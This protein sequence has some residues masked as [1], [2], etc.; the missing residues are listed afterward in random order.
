[1]GSVREKAKRIASID[2]LETG[3]CAQ[4]WSSLGGAEISCGL[5]KEGDILV[6]SDSESKL[7]RDKSL[8]RAIKNW[9]VKYV[10][11]HCE[12]SKVNIRSVHQQCK[13]GESVEEERD[14]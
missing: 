3:S 13:T 2:E 10:C 6:A 7:W 1:M 9:N 11:R 12:E 5:N 8:K 14:G 4:R